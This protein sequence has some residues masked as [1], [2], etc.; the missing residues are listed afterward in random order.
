MRMLNK[1]KEKTCNFCRFL[2][3]GKRAVVSP[4]RRRV[5]HGCVALARYNTIEQL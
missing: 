1:I 2:I 5:V 3:G 4:G